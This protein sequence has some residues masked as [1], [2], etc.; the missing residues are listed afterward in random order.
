MDAEEK[1][2]DIE[3]I[4]TTIATLHEP[5]ALI[6]LCA[7]GGDGIVSGYYDDHIALAREAKR[8]SE[9]SNLRGVMSDPFRTT[10][11]SAMSPHRFF[12]AGYCS[13]AYSAFAAMRTGSSESASFQRVR[14][15]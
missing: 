13:F 6:E 15:S 12:G 7:L 9:I 8:L 4:C 3:E 5:D 14:N 10:P 2:A 1:K 11:V